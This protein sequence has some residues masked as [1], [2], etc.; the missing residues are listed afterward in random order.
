MEHFYFKTEA[1]YDAMRKLTLAQQQ[2]AAAAATE[3]DTV[4]E[5]DEQVGLLFI[6]FPPPVPLAP[7]CFH[8]PHLFPNLSFLLHLSQL[9]R[10]C[11]PSLPELSSRRRRQFYSWLSCLSPFV[12]PYPA[13]LKHR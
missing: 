4:E 10:T 5:P 12:N 9:S 1:V 8:L 3:E 11:H 6:S 2:E 7:M 13:P